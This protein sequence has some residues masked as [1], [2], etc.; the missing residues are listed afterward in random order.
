MR[1]DVGIPSHIYYWADGTRRVCASAKKNTEK[2]NKI[3]QSKRVQR[4]DQEGK[5][6]LREGSVYSVRAGF[7]HFLVNLST[8]EFLSPLT[9]IY[10]MT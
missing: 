5:Y 10:I 4:N 9:F 2:Q 1:L 3:R 8:M 7:Y 6:K